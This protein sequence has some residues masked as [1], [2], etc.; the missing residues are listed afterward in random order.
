MFSGY[1]L[2]NRMQQATTVELFN[3]AFQAELADE[4][5]AIA[6]ANLKD[7]GRRAIM[8]AEAIQQLYPDTEPDYQ[9]AIA[10]HLRTDFAAINA[11]VEEADDD[12]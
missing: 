11:A 12:L 8:D 9:R 3:L 6:L 1:Q 5:R 7:P 10:P 4:T 2:Q